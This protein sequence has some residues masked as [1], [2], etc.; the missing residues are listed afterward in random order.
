MFYNKPE[1]AR[2]LG[3]RERGIRN[4]NGEK[5]FMCVTKYDHTKCSKLLLKKKSGVHV[6]SMQQQLRVCKIPCKKYEEYR[7][8]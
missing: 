4:D 3:G 8:D 2:F 5:T 6:G 7:K 1:H